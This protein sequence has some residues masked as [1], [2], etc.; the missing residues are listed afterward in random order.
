MAT[1]MAS[2]KVPIYSNINSKEDMGEGIVT[3]SYVR[4]VY[5][6]NMCMLSLFISF[7]VCFPVGLLAIYFAFLGH[8]A[9]KNRDIY[10]GDYLTLISG[11]ISIYGI[12]VSIVLSIATYFL[13][14][15]QD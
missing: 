6:S 11:L 13:Y 12:I 15:Y 3:S 2:E 5:Q 4:G 14:I 9:Y 7:F 8:V 1:K 10:N